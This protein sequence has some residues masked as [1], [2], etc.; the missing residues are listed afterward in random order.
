MVQII[1]RIFNRFVEVAILLKMQKLLNIKICQK[2][3]VSIKLN[4][5]PNIIEDLGTFKLKDKKHRRQVAIFMNKASR[6]LKDL[7][8]I[9]VTKVARKNNTVSLHAEW[10]NNES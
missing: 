10:K 9:Y 2:K 6:P 8:A 4:P 7:I 3:K 5:N 1:L